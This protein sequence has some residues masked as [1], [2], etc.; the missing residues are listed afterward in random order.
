[1]LTLHDYRGIFI[2]LLVKSVYDAFVQTNHW[3]KVSVIIPAYWL[4][5]ERVQCMY[6]SSLSITIPPKPDITTTSRIRP[7]LRGHDLH[8]RRHPA[9]R[10]ARSSNKYSTHTNSR[11]TGIT[12]GFGGDRR[13]E[14]IIPPAACAQG[15]HD[16]V[17]ESSCNGMFGVPWDGDTISPPDVCAF[18][19][20]TTTLRK[21]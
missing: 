16:F 8:H 21:C 15:R 4:Q 19:L 3:W 17:I 9:T 13:V 18:P 7:W 5:Y 6:P 10:F 11:F 2:L 1:M 20:A 12:G 14:Y